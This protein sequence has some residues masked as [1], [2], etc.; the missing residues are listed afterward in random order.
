MLSRSLVLFTL[1]VL[2]FVASLRP[3]RRDPAEPYRDG[4]PRYYLGIATPQQIF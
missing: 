2:G 4:E 1:A 3:S